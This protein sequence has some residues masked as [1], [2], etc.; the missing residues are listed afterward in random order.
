MF[1]FFYQLSWG[2][3]GNFCWRPGDILARYAAGAF[4]RN[5]TFSCNFRQ[6]PDP[7]GFLKI[8]VSARDPHAA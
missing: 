3:G 6:F 8:E 2:R 7:Y 1:G 4:A 5:D